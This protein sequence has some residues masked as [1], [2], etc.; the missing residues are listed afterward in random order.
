MSDKQN[1]NL[2]TFREVGELLLEQ[3]S[4]AFKA[5]AEADNLSLTEIQEQVRRH[6]AL[7]QQCLDNGIDPA[8]VRYARQPH[9]EGNGSGLITTHV[10]VQQP[11]DGNGA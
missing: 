9:Q 4:A 6:R 10:K 2:P 7:V 8:K 5:E 3:A 1:F 11:G